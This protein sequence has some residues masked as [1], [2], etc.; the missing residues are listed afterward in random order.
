MV[1]LPA[2]STVGKVPP[3]REFDAGEG[4][5]R[6]RDVPFRKETH[7][8]AFGRNVEFGP[9]EGGAEEDVHLPGLKDMHDRQQRANLDIGVGLLQRLAGSGLLNGF[10]VLHEPGRNG[11]VAQSR[12]D[13]P[14]TQQDAPLVV[15]DAAG[16]DLRVLVVD[17]AAIR[18]DVAWQMIPW[19]N[20][21][22]YGLAALAAEVHDVDIRMRGS[23]A[24]H[25][26]PRQR[27][28]AMLTTTEDG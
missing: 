22:L 28:A 2:C 20:A 9:G 23:A 6:P 25:L 17:R 11:P 4:D 18:A 8:E 26:F 21:K 10:A 27:Y 16:N 5:I 3:Q 15:G 7:L 14:A 19:R 12:L 1:V 24:A 13:G